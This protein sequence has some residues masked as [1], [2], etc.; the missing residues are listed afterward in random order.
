VKVII[1]TGFLN[2]D[3][4][5]RACKAAMRAEANFVKTSTGFG[6]GGAT[7]KDVSLMLAAVEGS[8]S[9]KASG[10]IRTW[11]TAQRMIEAGASRL[12]TSSG[13]AIIQGARG[14]E[15]K[16]NESGKSSY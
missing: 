14:M 1:E 5:E 7:E 2:D 9:V 3:E 15:T 12:G 4:K 6:P 13:V 11:E 16:E 8:L 10:G